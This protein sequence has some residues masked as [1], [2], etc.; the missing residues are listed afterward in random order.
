MDFVEAL[1]QSAHVLD[2]NI[3]T[4]DHDFALLASCTLCGGLVIWLL[5]PRLLVGRC[6][7]LCRMRNLLCE[8]LT[9]CLLVYDLP[10]RALRPVLRKT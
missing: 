3:V 2:Q 7:C 1:R 5:I 10:L 8:G 4:R 9:C 6:L